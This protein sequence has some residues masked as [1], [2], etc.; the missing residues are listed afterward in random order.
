M[1][2]FVDFLNSSAGCVTVRSSFCVQVR[3]IHRRLPPGGILVFMTGQREVE[4]L[5]RKLRWSLG[6]RAARRAATAEKARETAYASGSAGGGVPRG[7]AIGLDPQDEVI[8][9]FNPEGFVLFLFCRSRSH[10]FILLLVQAIRKWLKH[11]KIR[12]CHKDT[13]HVFW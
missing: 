8:T 6:P 7:A 1:I 12:Q 10:S 2:L 9:C 13:S 11:Q 3:Q 5:C 4:Q